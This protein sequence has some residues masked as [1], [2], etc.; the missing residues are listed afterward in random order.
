M[1]LFFTAADAELDENELEYDEKDDE[2]SM[3]I[4]RKICILKRKL[5]ITVKYS[6]SCFR[7]PFETAIRMYDTYEITLEKRMI[8]QNTCKRVAAIHWNSFL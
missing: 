2:G 7:V 5:Q 6:H 8:L 4:Q 3:A 1:V